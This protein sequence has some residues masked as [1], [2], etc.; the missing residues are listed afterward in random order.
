MRE[1]PLDHWKLTICR[2]STTWSKAGYGGYR[3]A[4]FVDGYRI[5]DTK[6]TYNED[7][8]FKR[9]LC[10]YY[11]GIDIY[12]SF[13]D[14]RFGYPTGTSVM[15]NLMRY[16]NPIIPPEPIKWNMAQQYAIKHFSCMNN[17]RINW[18]FEVV[19]QFVNPAKSPGYPYN[20]PYNGRPGFATKRDYLKHEDGQFSKENYGAYLERI[21][22]P[23]YRPTSFC[24]ASGKKELRKVSKI[25]ADE[26][27][28]Y[29]ASNCD[30]TLAGIG[31]T[32]EMNEK[33]YR[34][35]PSTSSFVGGSFFSGAW[36]QLF[37]RLSKHPHAFEMDVSAWDATLSREMI[38]SFCEVMWSF[39][40]IE[41]KT[42]TNRIRFTNLFREIWQTLVLC[43]DGSLFVKNQGNPSGS[44]L[45]IVTNTIIHYMLF[46]YAWLELNPKGVDT[47]Y[48]EFSEAVEL[49]LCGDDSLG[50]VEE[51]VFKWFNPTSISKVWRS[52]GIQLKETAVSDGLLL[53]RQ[54]LS[55]KTR[56]IRGRYIPF[57]DHNKA[58]STMIWKTRAHQS[59]KWSY[60][61]ACAMRIY[62]FNNLESNL[63]FSRYINYLENHPKYAKMLHAQPSGK[64]GDVLSWELVHTVYKTDVQIMRLYC[65]QFESQPKD[66]GAQ[67]GLELC[68]LLW[69]NDPD[70]IIY[71]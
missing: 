24:V 14:W 53:D 58:V 36:D 61:K 15:K 17:S 16:R 56:Q 59:I 29:L 27:R 67:V 28:A 11:N 18:D 45:T 57:P 42:P 25:V 13:P 46:V 63:L 55:Q 68:Q 71:A 3:P 9:F 37:Q 7:S 2:R 49:A 35:W 48:I 38:E 52:L 4:L 69:S 26:F 21:S 66:I 5:S 50:T 10:D 54:F 44:F 12:T 47:T 60:L 19:K 1:L 41:D 6:G 34:S 51:L 65:P 64:D 39:V 70:D 43:P 62:T 33:F 20:R 30:N 31:A 23:K 8:Y 32:G 40:Y 22:Q